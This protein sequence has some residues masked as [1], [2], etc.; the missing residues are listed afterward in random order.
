M[1]S[2]IKQFLQSIGGIFMLLLVLWS[3]ND[4]NDLGIGILPQ[5]D[6]INVYNIV[7]KDG[8]QGYTFLEDSIITSAS[9]KNLLGSMY[10]PTFGKTTVDF[11]TQFRL[12]SFPAFG[13][14]PVVDSVKLYLFY[15]TIYGD[16][17][18]PQRVKVYELESSLDPEFEYDQNIDLKG[19]SYDK[20]LADHEFIP[21]TKLD[22]VDNDTT[23][24][25][26]IPLD[27]SIGEKIVNA[28]SLD[29]INNDVFLELF[30]GL[31][32]ESEDVN[33]E[34]SGALITLEAAANSNFQGSAMVIY[35]NNDENMAEE[36]PDTLSKP[37]IITQ[38]SARVNSI[39]HDY[40][41]T[42]FENELDQ[43]EIENEYLYVQPTGGLKAKIN[44]PNLGDWKDSINFAINKAELIFKVDKEASDIDNFEPPSSLIFTFIDV[45]GEE[46]IP[47]DYY[48]SPDY[49]G[50]AL[51]TSDYTYSF[52]I[53]QHMQRIIDAR[54][55]DDEEYV[56]NQGFFLTTG[57]RNDFANRVVLEGTKNDGVELIITYSKFYQ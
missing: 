12:T 31:Y 33:E 2:S 10:E 48:F 44:I 22:T 45:D 43:E 49:Y 50:G 23:Y 16:H 47:V 25:L 17:T 1:K 14:N 28:D 52:N 53:T 36:E 39:D 8:I 38:Y 6:L 35:Y 13:T 7:V 20:I 34:G 46:R 51:D 15:A 56:G 41:G 4:Q 40:S 24:L 57:Q 26:T 9:E 55:P 5:E 18:T 19:M 11:A 21:A 37:F 54:D 30:K 3:C 29:L 27:N 42:P 32:I